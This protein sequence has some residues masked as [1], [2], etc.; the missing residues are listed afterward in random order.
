MENNKPFSI[1]ARIKS[2]NYAVKGLKVFF[3]TQHNAWIHALAIVMVIIL[4][5]VLKVS[6]AEWCLLILAIALVVITEMLNTAI[7]FL[8]D[9]VSPNFNSHAG[10]IKDVAAGAVLIAAIASCVIGGFIF[11]PKIF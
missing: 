4:G 6:A 1:V 11:L 8:T 3:S 5:F 9:L 2:F 10:K 7:E